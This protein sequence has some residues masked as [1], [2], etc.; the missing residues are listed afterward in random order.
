ME[1][2]ASSGCWWRTWCVRE[3]CSLWS[4]LLLNG[5]RGR[6]ASCSG[7]GRPCDHSALCSCSTLRTWRC[8]RFRPLQSATDSSCTT[9]SCTYSANCAK[10]GDATAQ[11]LVKVVLVT[12]GACAG[13]DSA[14]FV[15]ILQFWTRL[16][17]CRW[18]AEI[19]EVWSSSSSTVWVHVPAV[20]QR[21]VPMV[22][23][24]QLVLR[25]R[26]LIFS[27]MSSG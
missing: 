5:E 4:S 19:V 23:T 16:L 6:C 26:Q 2:L 15:E 1:W 8:L 10:T 20:M 25:R 22:Q 11:F 17:V 14:E 9:E 3:P 7:Y 12:T 18:C 13:P 21:L 27:M 24:V